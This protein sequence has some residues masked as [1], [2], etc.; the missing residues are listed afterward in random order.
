MKNKKIK[1]IVIGF[2]SQF[3]IL[4]LGL[5][6]PRIILTHYG[7]DVNGLTGTV[8]QIFTY[9]A[10]LEAGISQAARN[11]L[12]KPIKEGDKEG[13]CSVLSSAQAYYRK[14][15][16][17][18][19]LI[20]VIMAF[21]MPLVI[22]TQIGY[23]TV[24]FVILFE[25]MTN[26]VA[27]YFINTWTCFLMA[28]GN[29]YVINTINLVSKVLCYAI[30][31]V[32]AYL[33]VNIA[34]IQLGYF[35]VSLI[36]MVLYYRYIRKRYPWLKLDY[37]GKT[38]ALKDRNSFMISEFAWVVFSST[39]MI[40]LSFF[41]STSLASVYSIYSM[42]FT[43]LN[44]LLYVV[45]TSLYYNLGLIYQDDIREYEKIH[46]YYNGL[47]L[48]IMTAM[49]ATTYILIGPFI[50]L[51]T[52][53][54][55]DISYFYDGLPMMFCLV[56]II[57]WSRYVNGNLIMMA[58]YA[59]QVSIIAIIEAGLNL[60]LSVI[61]VNYFGIVGVLFATVVAL[62]IKVVYCAYISDKKI[63]KRSLVCSI[64]NIGINFVVF[65]LVAFVNDNISLDISSYVDFLVHGLVITPVI[66]IVVVFFN[67]VVNKHFRTTRYLRVK[68]K[69]VRK[70]I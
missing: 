24:F 2:S 35:I 21:V 50:G 59:K 57:S 40:V 3:I 49:M 19:G 36:K 7:S 29:S 12:Y 22:K 26:V 44:S 62:P 17:L 53:G 52:D 37:T 60:T 32:L 55:N 41:V 63:L 5:I 47:F 10:I 56:Q 1:N 15:T 4:A 45:Y 51:Y 30:K 13:I 69:I 18:Y 38:I 25:G 46:D 42:V 11:M 27:F 14:V 8:G 66:V 68:R 54:V 31:I 70:K 43:N 48:G 58:G 61:L 64:K 9:L 23:G 65:F 28:N 34:L 16:R 20:V 6:I 67:C 39:D 33:N